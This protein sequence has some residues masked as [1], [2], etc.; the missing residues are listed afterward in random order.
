MVDRNRGFRIPSKKM[1]DERA[2]ELV[3]F[4]N[5]E[6]VSEF[7]KIFSTAKDCDSVEYAI[8]IANTMLDGAEALEKQIGEDA[9]TPSKLAAIAM[10]YVASEFLRRHMQIHGIT[11]PE[12]EKV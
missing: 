3:E 11:K 4:V 12:I 6:A 2:A 5:T 7:K 10:S 8:Q 1:K 9:A